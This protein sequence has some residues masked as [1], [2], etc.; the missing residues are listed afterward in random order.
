[1]SSA[2]PINPDGAAPTATPSADPGLQPGQVFVLAGPCWRTA[3]GAGSRDKLER[4]L[5]ARRGSTSHPVAPQMPLERAQNDS[6]A[7]H[8]C[9][10]CAIVNDADARFCKSCGRAL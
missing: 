5:A 3:A 9:T 8:A 4:D 7:A 1:M 2:T 6:T 10:A